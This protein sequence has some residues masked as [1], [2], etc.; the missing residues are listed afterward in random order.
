MFG[1]YTHFILMFF[2]AIIPFIILWLSSFKLL[3][4]F[5]KILIFVV[6]G[7]LIFGGTWDFFGVKYNV[8]S[9]H[10]IIGLWF[11]GLPIE[12]W[13]FIII[14]SLSVS[15]LTLILIKRGGK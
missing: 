10:N 15:S 9:F 5:K 12:E 7:S 4:K 11:F 3:L 1:I 14:I 8:W 6:I 2:C 13:C